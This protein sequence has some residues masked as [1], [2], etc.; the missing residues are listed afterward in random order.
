MNNTQD[1]LKEVES[2]SESEK[3]MKEKSGSI[4]FKFNKKTIKYITEAVA[5]LILLYWGLNNTEKV[6]SVIGTLFNVIEPFLLG[7]AIAFVI[8]VLLRPLE[9]LWDKLDKKKKKTSVKLKRPVCLIS[10]TL[11]MLGAVFALLFMVIPEFTST[12]KTIAN[13]VPQYLSQLE[14]WLDTAIGFAEKYGINLPEFSF[15]AEKIMSVVGNVINSTGIVDKTL[16]FTGSLV[17]GLVNLIIALAF[18]FYLLAQKEKLSA[19]TKKVLFAFFPEKKVTNLLNILKLTDQT[20]TN[21]VSGQLL[22]AVI[23][24]VLC[25]IGMLIFR[26]PYSAVISVL[27]GFTALIPVFG[28][29]IGTAIGAFLILFVSPIKAIWFVVF[30]V[31]LQ[32]LEGNLI[33]PKVVGKSVGLPG[34]LVLTAVSIGGSLMG[35]LGILV[36]VPVCAVLYTLLKRAVNIINKKRHATE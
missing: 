12:I 31:V 16:D 28:A 15:N 17:S 32:Q 35:V 7:F 3:E 23:I 4:T 24:G 6:S 5:F 33:Y 18:S 14:G 1:E 2:V 29:F 22:E 27:V 9:S 30:I 10:S 34:I 8:N 19:N 13:S 36:S 21:F 11:I 25:F 20:F 26:M